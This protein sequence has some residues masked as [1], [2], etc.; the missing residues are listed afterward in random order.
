MMMTVESAHLSE[1]QQSPQPCLPGEARL[2]T[3]DYKRG[4][5]STFLL[6]L[7]IF[8]VLNAGLSF[9][10]PIHFDPYKFNCRGYNWWIM[11]DL[12]SHQQIHNVA[13]LGSSTMISAVAGSDA[14]YL[15]KSLDMTKH[16]LA[17][18]LDSKLQG[19]FG[20]SFD[21]FSLA[22][23]GQMPSDAFLSLKAMVNTSNRP[24]VVIYGVAPRDFIDSTLAGPSDTEPFLYLTRF[25]NID[26]VAAAVFRNPI[27]K[28]EW[29][30]KKVVYLFGYSLDCKLVVL[31][32]A[33]AVFDR[34]LPR[35]F[36]QHPFTWWDRVRMLPGYLPT[37]IRP[38]AVMTQP[39][40]AE[41]ARSHYKDS[42][43]E[44]LQRYKSPDPRTYRTQMYFLRKMAEY[45]HKERIE[46]VIVNMPITF[47][48]A[49]MLRPGI[50]SKY[51]QSLQQFAWNYNVCYYDLCDFASF[52]REDFHDDV[53][54]N[55]FGGQKFFDRVVAAMAK[56]KRAAGA[57]A[58]SGME[59]ANRRA[60]AASENK[61]PL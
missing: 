50:Y 39:I 36:S 60:I 49:S 26:D 43:F 14:N 52:K 41:S 3:P 10:N 5:K 48:N 4:F 27:T 8:V 18:Y 20:G 23:P 35:P 42:T 30:L 32:E 33:S 57:M 31:E 6:G 45:C 55:A 54:M 44:Y 11:N 21:S 12:R 56:E 37:E 7:A 59:M 9:F 53:H 38:E 61:P 46:L 1:L 28:L 17:K 58:M 29:W 16:H 13:L 51:L 40:D 47:Y 24:D 19:A 25:V 34:M 2:V 15:G 22:A